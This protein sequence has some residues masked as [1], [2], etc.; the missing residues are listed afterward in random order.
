MASAV[1]ILLLVGSLGGLGYLMTRPPAVPDVRIE[2]DEV[3]VGVTGSRWLLGMRRGFRIPVASVAGV[4]VMPQR[5]V[6]RPWVIRMGVEG[7]RGARLGSYGCAPERDFWFTR[8]G[9]E[10]LVVE[11]HPGEPYRRLVIEVP[12]PR[13]LALELRPVLGALVGPLPG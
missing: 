8:G 7:P 2:G 9:D 4:A 5:L 11:L 3:V 6:P 10:F 13:A 1:A 12:D